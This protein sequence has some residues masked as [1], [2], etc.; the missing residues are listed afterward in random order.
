[1][2]SPICDRG[3]QTGNGTPNFGIAGTNGQ[4]RPQMAHPIWDLLPQTADLVDKV[5][6]VS[7]NPDL[8]VSVAATQGCNHKK[9]IGDKNPR[10]G[11][12]TTDWADKNKMRDTKHPVP[13]K[14]GDWEQFPS[15]AHPISNWGL[16]KAKPAEKHGHRRKI[17]AA[18][19]K[20]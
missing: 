18:G 11:R 10:L 1:M 7:A 3:L 2:L 19:P 5:M 14:S 13:I 8:L 16:E 17:V 20:K 12:T 4:F 9:Q 15:A 6:I